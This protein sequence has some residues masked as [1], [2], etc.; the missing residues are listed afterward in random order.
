MHRPSGLASMSASILRD[1]RDADFEAIWAL[2]QECFPPGIAYSRSELRA[3]LSA[4]QAEAIVAERHGRVIAFVLGGRRGRA[5]HVI[6]LD[7]AA[8]A[9]RQGVGRRLLVEL[10]R[11]LGAAGATRVE[12]ETAVGNR[13]AI[14]FYESLGYRKVAHLDGYYGPGLH[15]WRMAKR[16]GNP[17]RAWPSPA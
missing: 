1:C 13:T 12:L 15:A 8:R 5:G 2:D 10:E 6:T 4:S 16:L 7:V 9:R 17:A 14:V 3:F 11:R